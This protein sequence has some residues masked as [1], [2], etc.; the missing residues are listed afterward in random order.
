MATGQGEEMVRESSGPYCCAAALANERRACVWHGKS[1]G[2]SKR[3]GAA[4][5]DQ[6]RGRERL[7]AP[8]EGCAAQG[9]EE[10]ACDAGAARGD[11]RQP[12][13]SAPLARKR[14]PASRRNV[15]AVPGSIPALEG[16]RRRRRHESRTRS[17]ARCSLA[18]SPW[19]GDVQ[20]DTAPAVRI[21]PSCP[22]WAPGAPLPARPSAYCA[23]L[24]GH[25]HTL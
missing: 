25:T 14:R 16:P 12:P 20:E 24:F 3:G 18:A 13:L 22:N 1:R 11:A 7:R 8:A 21:G 5:A 6:S 19:R 2:L 10:C 4:A 15:S 17:V 23:C 9:S